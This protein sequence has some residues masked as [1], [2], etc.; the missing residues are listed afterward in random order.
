MKDKIRWGEKKKKQMQ[1][2]T[3]KSGTP[4]TQLM[5]LHSISDVGSYIGMSLVPEVY[6]QHWNFCPQL[7]DVSELYTSFG[8]LLF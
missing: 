5:Q 4:T 2:Q 1:M 3:E 8:V 7:S 6:T